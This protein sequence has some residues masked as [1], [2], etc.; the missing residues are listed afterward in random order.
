MCA[1]A[2]LSVNAVKS[3]LLS[4]R[5]LVGGAIIVLLMNVV[6]A[7]LSERRSAIGDRQCPLWRSCLKIN[8]LIS[9]IQATTPSII[10]LK[11]ILM[12]MAIGRTRRAAASRERPA[13]WGRHRHISLKINVKAFAEIRALLSAQLIAQRR[14]WRINLYFIRTAS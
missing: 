12:S 3:L 7:R 6:C 5:E 8:L 1:V 4:A 11:P 9:E 2:G 13:S 10:F 14:K